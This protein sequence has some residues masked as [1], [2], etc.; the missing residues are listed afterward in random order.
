LEIVEETRISTSKF[1]NRLNSIQPETRQ[2]KVPSETRLLDVQ[3]LELVELAGI[4][5]RRTG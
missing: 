5:D 3:P 2:F 4:K 1:E